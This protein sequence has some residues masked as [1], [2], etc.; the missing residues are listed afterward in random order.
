[1]AIEKT[2]AVAVL[3]M[4]ALSVVKDKKRQKQINEEH[5]N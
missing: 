3:T 2:V 5:V 1:M 4:F